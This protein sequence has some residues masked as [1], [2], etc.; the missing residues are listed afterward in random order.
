MITNHWLIHGD[1]RDLVQIESETIDLVVTSPPYPMI[2]MWDDAFNA[3]N[4]EIGLTLS[5]GDGQKAFELMHCELDRAWHEVYRVLK[6]GGIV[7]INIGDA[8]RKVGG[9]FQLFPN[10]SRILE[11]T[12]EIGFQTLPWIIWRKPTNS[13]TK[14]MGSG[15][16]PPGAYVTLEHEFILILR[17]GSRREFKTDKERERRR[18]SAYFW[19]ERNRWFS[20]IWFDLTGTGQNL[21]E[22]APRERSAAFPLELPYRLI[23][24]YSIYGDTVL[25]PFLGTG[26]T[27]VAALM[28]ARNSI[29]V[30]IEEGMFSSVRERIRR[31]PDMAQRSVEQ[32]IERHRTFTERRATDQQKT[33]LKYVNRSLNMPVMSRHEADLEILVLEK[34]DELR[35]DEFRGHYRLFAST[36]SMEPV[37]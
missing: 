37:R 27:T 11:I 14:F 2:Q 7:C 31:T 6:L 22:T 17:K 12:T 21:T 19:E 20:D 10:H 23:Q 26:T 36:S 8:T 32:R 30:D 34:V 18:K 16:I 33:Q 4:P 35:K 25:D 5:E 9:D 28:T 13:P 1:A 29:G 15:M 24:M 3:M